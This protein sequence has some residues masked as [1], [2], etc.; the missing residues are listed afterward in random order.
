MPQTKVLMLSATPVNTSLI[1]L[2]NQIYL[3]T[4][5]RE[6]VFQKSL[7]IGNIRALLGQAQRT[8]KAWEDNPDAGGGR[9]KLKLLNELGADFFQLLGGV[10]IARSRR[11]IKSFYADE[12]ER[13]G[14]FPK[15]PKPE[16]HHPPTDLNGVLS[17]K[18][19]ADQIEEFSLSIYTPSSYVISEEAIQRL[20]K[21]K[22]AFRFNQLDR[23]KFLIGMMQTNFLK[24]LESS[25]HSLTE[26][27]ERT[28]G[29]IDTLLEKIDRYEQNQQMLNA[30]TEVLLD[31]DI[32]P[33][34]DEDD[35]EFLVNKAR[36]PYHLEELDCVRW[37]EDLIK[38]KGTLSKAYESVKAIT[39]DRDG[40]LQAIKTH[41]R[42]K[43]EHPPTDK[44]GE[45]NRKLL[46]FTTFKDTAEYL[47]ENL[48]D[49]AV[50]LNLNMAMVSGDV[51]RTQS[52]PNNFNAILTNF[53]PRARGRADN[54]DNE[55]DLLIATDC[56]SEGQNLQDCDTVLNYDIPLE[57][58]AYHPTLRPH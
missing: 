17:Y 23:E 3:M 27:L 22:Q 13:I 36:H 8:F 35:E 42:D 11:H 5:K 54:G 6:D 50:E 25:A 45:T 1:D 46:V 51:T 20:A 19:L 49:L 58:G 52:R 28:I 43:A 12:I 47:Y 26:T 39:P 15:Q 30:D 18:Y 55:I 56:I 57:S 33:E 34:D 9:D 40:K 10:S 48:S 21:E 41:I 38:D 4:E 53:A 7:G 14:E 44:D 16:N 2:R 29:K 31:D 32:L 24:R 37:K